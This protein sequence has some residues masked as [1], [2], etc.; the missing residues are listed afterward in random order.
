MDAANRCA[1]F[2]DIIDRVT[3]SVAKDFPDLEP[4]DL[5]QELYLAVLTHRD[6]I[7]EP[8]EDNDPTALILHIAKIYAR[9]NRTQALTL[10]PQYSYR[11]SD[12]RKI[13]EES[14]W[15]YSQWNDGY[16]PDDDPSEYK[17]SDNVIARADIAW[18]IDFLPAHYKDAILARFRDG[19][20]PQ[21]ATPEYRKLDRSLRKLTD[22]LNSYKRDRPADGP[23]TRRVITNATARFM[24]DKQSD[25]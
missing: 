17:H 13:L 6:K 10:S 19:I 21:Q 4:E 9:K 20:L 7:P 22:I 25:E 8:D 3:K 11:Q 1:A 16:T 23:G 12:V 14:M 18:A 15:Y 24:I 2:R 5:S